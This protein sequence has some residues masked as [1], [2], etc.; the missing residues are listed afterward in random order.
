MVELK[1]DWW[2]VRK[3]QRSAAPL[4]EWTAVRKEQTRAE[5]TVD[6]WVDLKAVQ[7]DQQLVA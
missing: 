7:S 2:A 5:K 4:V 6:L 1:V 3:V